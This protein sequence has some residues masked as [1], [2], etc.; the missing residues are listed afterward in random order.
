MTMNVLGN[1][2]NL[3]WI[4]FELLDPLSNTSVDHYLL[5]LYPNP[6]HEFVTLQSDTVINHIK[7]YDLLG[8]AVFEQNTKNQQIVQFNVTQ[9]PSGLYLIEVK[10]ENS[11]KILKLIKQ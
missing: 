1:Q 9:Y 4:E 11:T 5:N 3:N 2:F 7:V 6:A 8:R 10:S